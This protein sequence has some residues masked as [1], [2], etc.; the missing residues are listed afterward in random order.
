MPSPKEN[1]EHCYRDGLRDLKLNR[2]LED[3]DLQPSP[4]AS[5]AQRILCEQYSKMIS[6]VIT[7][8]SFDRPDPELV[9]KNGLSALKRI[10]QFRFL[11]D[12][13]IEA[14]KRD[15][16]LQNCLIRYHELG[17]IDFSVANLTEEKRNSPWPFNRGVG[18]VLKKLWERLR[19]AALT[20]MEMVIS[21]IKQIPHLVS[22][23]PKAEI[24]VS[25]PFPTFE[26]QIDI[27][28][29][30]VTLHEFFRALLA[31]E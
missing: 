28:V 30:P 31:S 5:P 23:K 16:S 21:A 18:R 29:E 24:G 12:N 22:L 26:V 1:F 3:P 2:T 14:V 20:V 11:L 9:Y 8:L 10:E 19:D 15:D 13:L 27:E 4:D 6:D 17:L 25:G 7:R